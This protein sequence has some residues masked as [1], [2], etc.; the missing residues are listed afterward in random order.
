MK[1][2]ILIFSLLSV[3]PMGYA[4]DELKDFS[5][6]YE[7]GRGMRL[8]LP[9]NSNV[10]PVFKG[11]VKELKSDGRSVCA[12]DDQSINCWRKD[13]SQDR[14]S[15][16][17]TI[18]FNV[19]NLKNPKNLQVRYDRACLIDDEILKCWELSS[20]K[21]MPV[22]DNIIKPK[23]VS[24]GFSYACAL[25]NDEVKCWTDRL[26]VHSILNLKN[27][28]NLI[29]N[30]AHSCAIDDEGV[31]CWDNPRFY[32]NEELV[33][34]KANL[35]SAEIPS[36]V[37]L[38]DEGL[39]AMY[40]TNV[41][42]RS[43]Q[44]VGT[45]VTGKAPSDVSLII[46]GLVD[47]LNIKSNKA[48]YAKNNSTVSCISTLTA[49]KFAYELTGFTNP[50]QLEVYTYGYSETE[51]CV[52]DEEGV[53]C[54]EKKPLRITAG[55]DIPASSK[56]IFLPHNLLKPKSIYIDHNSTC[57]IDDIGQV[58]WHHYYG[59]KTH[60]T[61]V[62]F[63]MSEKVKGAFKVILDDGVSCF[64]GSEDFKCYERHGTI[65][66]Q[67]QMDQLFSSDGN[68]FVNKLGLA[69]CIDPHTKIESTISLDQSKYFYQEKS[70]PLAHANRI[71]YEV[72]DT[73]GAVY[74]L[75]VLREKIVQ[76]F[77]AGMQ[78]ESAEL[79]KK[80]SK[81]SENFI[82]TVN[83]NLNYPT[84]DFSQRSS[85]QLRFV[86]EIISRSLISSKYLLS[87]KSKQLVDMLIV[88]Y[89]NLLLEDNISQQAAIDVIS[90][91]LNEALLMQEFQTS[92]RLI[93][94][95]SFFDWASNYVATGNI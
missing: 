7:F 46:D 71:L 54:H 91:T 57:A 26:K 23:L 13:I 69:K 30:G 84:I 59:P 40:G 89:S 58:C 2:I 3:L 62:T 45:V 39:C 75:F 37:F 8:S 42:C 14:D 88:D 73:V 72:E 18:L 93:G 95:K 78:T 67:S 65:K 68:C 79:I 36:K 80:N 70:I 82:V 43:W 25:V 19:D 55:G 28:S 31:K 66:Y 47:T 27:P 29:S 77:L 15:L 5:K 48:C 33:A 38:S 52:V 21:T 17:P 16:V 90:K 44:D 10:G 53:I 56:Y 94:I 92:Y 12:L 11:K 76:S 50:R 61:K 64:L 85:V 22:P 60:F 32:S 74:S 86:L 9:I 6:N 41:N 49:E 63:N 4:Q 81:Y 34:K 51:Y 24:V 87:S 83:K 20:G 1:Y 35:L